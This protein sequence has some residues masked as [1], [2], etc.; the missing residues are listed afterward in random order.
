MI[1]YNAL[2]NDSIC[3][4]HIADG[5]I[6]SVG[7][8][9]AV[10]DLDAC[11][12]SVI[13]GLIDIHTHGIGGV[14]T[15]DADFEALCRLYAENGTTSFLPTTMTM[16]YESLKKVCNA[17]TDF[18][19]AQIL[20]FHLEGPYISEKYKGAQNEKFIKNPS[21]DEF[22]QFKNVK[23]ITL[24]PEKKGSKEFIKAVSD[25][26][27][28]SIGHT[29]CD[30]KTAVEAIEDGAVCLTHMFNVMPS[31]HH[32]ETGPIGAAF[33]KKIYAQ[34]ICDGL[35]VSPSM[36]RMAYSMFGDERLILISDSLACAQ[37]PDGEYESGGLK[38]TLKNGQARLKDG[39][40]AGSSFTLLQCVKKAVEIGIPF[41]SAVKMATETPAKL[42]GLNKGKIAQG[43]DA[44][45]LI[46]DKEFDI[47]CRI[48]G[49][50][51]FK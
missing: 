11:G 39:T 32:R 47:F 23:M 24:A 26:C 41:C 29:D 19:G 33:D 40:L 6:T 48:I 42:L 16:D 21:V 9:T 46:I 50:K 36:V 20:G 10:G 22:S 7:E 49:G 44:D 27:I 30:Y 45:L 8:N 1:I 2:V 51:I 25:K 43:Y 15:M 34:L 5:K 14:D 35:H 3:S 12:N 4:I 28:V 18:D 38:V 37:L 17:K 31:L 13:P